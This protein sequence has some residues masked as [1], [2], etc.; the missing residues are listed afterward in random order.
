MKIVGN[1]IWFV[2]VGLF[3]AIGW[4]IFGAILCVTIIGIP[5]AKQCFK[6]AKLS[7][8]PFGKTVKTDFEK[9]P[10]G[11]IIW[12][13]LFGWEL[14]LGY[15]IWGVIFYITIIGIPFGKQCFKLTKLSL[16]PMGAKIS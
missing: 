12:M 16:M 1:I 7:L 5:F 15:L 2:L 8:L 10:V 9:H 3:S 14:A 13:I 6:I 11:N 4:C